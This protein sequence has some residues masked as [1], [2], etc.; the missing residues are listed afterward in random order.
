MTLQTVA[1][2]AAAVLILIQDRQQAV[3]LPQAK[4]IMAV[5]QLIILLIHLQD[6]AAA[7]PV[8]LEQALLIH[9]LSVEQVEP[10]LTL[11]HHGYPLS[12]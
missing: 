8:L 5:P 1:P 7:V 2:A 9:L 12:V 3:Q 11:I 4:A 6:Q 10:V